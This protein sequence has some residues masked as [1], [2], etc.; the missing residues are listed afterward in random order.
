MITPIEIAIVFLFLGI[1]SIVSY[2][3]H[4]LDLDGI[5]I[6]DAVGVASITWGPNPAFNFFTVLLFFF[7]GQI[8]FF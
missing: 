2:K 8:V 5:I 7:I 4:L 6:A 3:K 1:F